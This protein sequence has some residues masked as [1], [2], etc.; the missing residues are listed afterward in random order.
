M[1]V[2]LRDLYARVK[3]L[4][5]TLVAGGDGLDGVVHWI[6]M[7][8]SSEVTTYLDR[9]DLA[10]CTGIGFTAAGDLLGL[11]RSTFEHEA[12]GI[13]VN[14]GPF[15]S[16]VPREVARYCDE[17]SYPLFRVPWD[18]H[19]AQVMHVVCLMIT[20]SEKEEFEVGLAFKN[21][22]LTPDQRELYRDQLARAG[23]D[24]DWNY[25]VAVLGFVPKP[26]SGA[27]REQ[28]ERLASQAVGGLVVRCGWKAATVVI[29]GHLCLV[30]AEYGPAEVRA[31]AREALAA[32]IGALGEPWEAYCGVG[33][34]T[35]SANCIGKS[36]RQGSVLEHMQHMQGRPGEVCA[37]DLLGCE[38][39]LLGVEDR[40][41][42]AEYVR[43]GVGRLVAY[44]EAH[45]SDLVAVLACYLEHNGSVKETS[46]LMYVHRNTIVY[47]LNKASSILGVSL[48]DFETRVE[49]YLGLKARRLGL[50]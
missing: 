46:E 13:I 32:S 39:V 49:L 30:F 45:G 43:E 2:R 37:Y 28:G 48:A 44:D 24:T 22:I 7:V 14:V 36:Y 19:L 17:H 18:V 31:M 27:E 47:K 10:C 42:L 11:V 40:G 16:E 20:L 38:R 4:G 23:Y 34:V 25:C 21:A 26:G 3:G 33:K 12:A 9:R 8:E 50:G 41:L 29:E 15:V 5:V 6:H 1:S 35:R